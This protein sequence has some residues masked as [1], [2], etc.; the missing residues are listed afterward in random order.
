MVNN[1]AFYDFRGYIYF[2]ILKGRGK[3]ETLVKQDL[4]WEPGNWQNCVEARRRVP[5]YSFKFCLLIFL[6]SLCYKV[7]LLLNKFFF[8]TNCMKKKN[9]NLYKFLNPPSYPLPPHLRRESIL[10]KKDGFFCMA[11][12]VRVKNKLISLFICLTFFLEW[13]K[14]FF[15]YLWAEN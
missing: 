13:S 1:S 5:M 10:R 9:Y 8:R 11:Q 4:Q 3:K 12:N 2:Y 15:P 6:P 14:Q 7:S